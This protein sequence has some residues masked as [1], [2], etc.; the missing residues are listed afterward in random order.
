MLVGRAQLNFVFLCTVWASR[1]SRIQPRGDCGWGWGGGGGEGEG[2]AK[3]LFCY[4]DC[5][6]QN[7]SLSFFSLACFILFFSLFLPWTLSFLS[8]RFLCVHVKTSW[9]TM[10]E[11]KQTGFFRLRWNS[12]VQS[13]NKRALFP[14]ISIK[15]HAFSVSLKF[16]LCFKRVKSNVCE[17]YINI[18]DVYLYSGSLDA[19][20]QKL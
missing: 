4:G 2:E 10:A 3:L 16:C 5:D 13:C 19:H 15:T 9:I 18:Y 14:N 6:K 8:F 17:P 11:G 7:I 1:W 12:A 20:V